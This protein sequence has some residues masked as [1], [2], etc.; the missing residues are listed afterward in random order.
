M[1]PSIARLIELQAVDLRLGDVQA[2]LDAL[3]KRV[4]AVNKR[5]ET[6]RQQLAEVKASLTNSLKDRKIFE[7]DVQAWKDKARKY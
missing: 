7:I 5:V 6:V 1:H 3:P 2:K 4:M